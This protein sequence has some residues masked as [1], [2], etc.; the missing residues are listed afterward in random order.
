MYHLSE[1]LKNWQNNSHTYL[2]KLLILDSFAELCLNEPL[3]EIDELSYNIYRK[4]IKHVQKLNHVKSLNYE[5]EQ[6]LIKQKCKGNQEAFNKL[7]YYQ[8]PTVINIARKYRNCGLPLND[9]ISEGNIGMMEAIRKV[10]PGRF[11]L[12]SYTKYYIKSF[13]HNAINKYGGQIYYPQ[14]LIQNISV[15]KKT[16]NRLELRL[17]H[18]PSLD[19][20][21][22]ASNIDIE[23]IDDILQFNNVEIS[24]DK[25]AL[26]LGDK[27]ILDELFTLY[28]DLKSKRF[29]DSYHESLV[30]DLD[31]CLNELHTREMK[32]LKYH[33]GI[34]CHE[35][36]FTE[37]GEIYDFTSDRV[38]QIKQ[39]AIKKLRRDKSTILKTYLG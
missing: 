10:E 21:A 35:L 30:I 14:N 6:S 17:G 34:G 27:H 32:I 5:E 13:I 4:E 16:I 1:L 2:T 29:E 9:L 23:L 33:Y 19:E 31:D 8:L 36:T 26:Y 39:N 37:I 22:E 18:T 20:I 3:R 28:E 12:C 11:R 25:L 7:I 24:L 38:S 15:I